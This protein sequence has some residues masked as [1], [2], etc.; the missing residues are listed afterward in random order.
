MFRR[1]KGQVR[2]GRRTVGAERLSQEEVMCLLSMRKSREEVMISDTRKKSGAAGGE[3][4]ER[5]MTKVRLEKY[6]GS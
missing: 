6:T 3:R 1:Q 2:A 4:W 5:Q